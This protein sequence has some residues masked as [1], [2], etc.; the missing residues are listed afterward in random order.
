[1]ARAAATPSGP[2]T[3]SLRSIGVVA[4]GHGASDFYSGMVPLLIFYLVIKQQHL[5][6]FLQGVAGFAWYFTSSIVQPV[7][8][9]YSDRHGRWWFLPVGVLLTIIAVGAIGFTRGYAALLVL[10]ALGGFGS[11]IM[12]PEAGKYAAQV[13]SRR[14]GSAISIFQIG[15]QIGYGIG[16]AVIAALLA[17]YG[18]TATAYAAIPGLAAVAG[19][20]WMMPHVD[21]RAREQMPEPHEARLAAGP[22]GTTLDVVLLVGS[23]GLRYLTSAAFM[24]YLPNALIARGESLLVAGQIVAAFLLVSSVGLFCGGFLGDRFGHRAVS[25][26]SLTLAVPALAG[27]FVLPHAFGIASL[28]LGSILLA[29]QN[30]PGVALTQALMP[31]NLGMALGLMNGVAFGVGSAMVAVLG[32]QVARAGAAATLHGVALVPL[33]AAACFAAVGRWSSWKSAA[34]ASR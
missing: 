32:V 20:F 29:V 27:F 1:M 33:V 19:L 2:G 18:A 23:T 5:S 26:I 7:F 11:A 3:W 22:R 8:G 34:S 10:I 13:G 21:A 12:H 25:F 9:W 16:P 17:R 28:L 14:H 30:A 15:G 24:T 4:F 31:R 6:P